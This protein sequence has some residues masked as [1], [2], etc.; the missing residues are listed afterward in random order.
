M[1]A[2]WLEEQDSFRKTYEIGLRFQRG[3]RKGGAA[4]DR[5]RQVQ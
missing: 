1:I 3:I 4:C 2:S 5:L